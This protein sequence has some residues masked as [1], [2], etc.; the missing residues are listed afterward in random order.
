MPSVTKNMMKSFRFA[1]EGATTTNGIKVIDDPNAYNNFMQLFGFTNADLSEAY[2]RASSMKKAEEKILKRR[3]QLLDL[4]YLAKTNGDDDML[5]KIKDDIYKY[6]AKV[7]AGIKITSDTISR[8]IRG[9][10]ER[11][12]QARDGVVISKKLKNDIVEKYGD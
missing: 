6:N 9:H 2:T 3:T 8:S 7:P 12:K 10:K 1:T 5:D 4:H 11:E